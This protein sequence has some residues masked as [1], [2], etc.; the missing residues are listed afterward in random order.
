MHQNMI[1][2]SQ[3]KFDKVFLEKLLNKLT[4]GNKRSLHLNAIPGR[5]KTKLDLMDISISV[6]QEG[7][8]KKIVENNRAHMFL[9]SLF[10]KERFSFPIY[11][12]NMNQSDM[13]E[14]VKE[15]L[16][17][18]SKKLDAIIMD[19]DEHYLETGSKNFGLGYPLLVKSDKKEPKNIIIA[20]IFIWSLD[21]VKSKRR[22]E[23]IISRDED[24]P[25]K[26]NELLISHIKKD[27]G[28]VLPTLD[29][30]EDNILSEREVID[31]I[32]KLLNSFNVSQRF[33][34]TFL[35][36]CLK[37]KEIESITNGSTWIQ[38]SGIF[39]LYNSPKQSIIEAT[40]ELI[41]N[42]DEFKS[43]TL[44][45]QP[46]QNVIS[47][48]F[49]VDPSQSKI[50]D[51]IDKNEFKVIQGPPGTGKSQA[52]SA[53]IS[54][55]LANGAKI[56]VVCEKKTALDV[57]EEN[58]KKK[59]L[60]TF[61]IVID[62][63]VK[64][65]SHVVKKARFLQ[66]TPLSIEKFDEGEFRTIHNRYLGLRNKINDLYQVSSKR[67]FKNCNL[68]DIIGNFL[69]YSK[70]EYF[71]E[72]KDKLSHIDF[73]FTPEELE[74]YI[75]SIANAILLCEKIQDIDE[76]TFSLIDLSQF[77]ERILL[78]DIEDIKQK[79][80]N[81]QEII[82]RT[83]SFLELSSF[84]VNG[85]SIGTDDSIL[86][87]EVEKAKSCLYLYKSIQEIYRDPFSPQMISDI[88]TQFMAWNKIAE[89]LPK[90][91]DVIYFDMELPSKIEF[92]D[93][94]INDFETISSLY[95]EGC[96][97]QGSRFDNKKI[98]PL[99][100]FFSKSAFEAYRCTQDLQVLFNKIK[101]CC[102]LL[103]ER[104]KVNVILKHWSQYPSISDILEASKVVVT[105]V[106]KK[107]EELHEQ[108]IL[109]Y[110]SIKHLV[111]KVEI[112]R[113][114]CVEIIECKK[115]IKQSA[116]E[117][118]RL[119][120]LINNI[121]DKYRSVE[122][123]M[124]TLQNITDSLQLLHSNLGYL[125]EYN[126]WIQFYNKHQG[127][128]K[129]F[130]KIPNEK[131]RESFLGVYYYYYI[132]N[133]DKN[134]G[135]NSGRD[136]TDLDRLR[137]TYSILQ[138]QNNYKIYN[139]WGTKRRKTIDRLELAVGFKTLFALKGTKRAGRKKSLRQ[140]IEWDFDAFTS[141][142]PVVMVNPVVANAL[143]PLKQGLFDLV[144]FDEASQ[145][146][147]ED[148]YTSMIRGKYKVVV[149]DKH[150]MPPSNYFSSNVES[151]DF[152]N[153]DILEGERMRMEEQLEAESLLTF[154]E[155]IPSKNSSN[156]DFHYR[157][158][159]PALIEFSNSAFYGGNLCPLPAKSDYCP[160]VLREVGGIYKS[161]SLEGNINSD[162][163]E[164]VLSILR[165]IEAN[166][167]GTM[168][169][170][171]VVTFNIHQRN[172]I[173]SLLDS[174]AT[175]DEQ[176]Q[177]K[178]IE[179][180]KSGLFVRNLENVQGD[181]RDVIILSTTFGNDEE[182]V[183]YERFG[184]INNQKGYRLINV[185]ITRAKKQIFLVTS[186]PQ[187]KYIKYKE[188]IEVS[189]ENNKKAIFYAYLAYAKAVSDGQLDIAEDI[190]VELRRFSYDRPK[191]EQSD[192]HHDTIGFTESPFEEEVYDEIIKIVGAEAVKIQ[193]K[194]GGY[195]LDFLVEFKGRKIA[196]ECDGKT[197]H[198]TEQAYIEDMH[199]Q[200]TL[201]ALGYIFYRVWSIN[202]FED[203]DKEISKFSRW[204]DTL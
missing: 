145:L 116:S 69:K 13:S 21:I 45:I 49:D 38:W 156:L 159:H 115:I 114:S 128:F 109:S 170:V 101:S 88:N 164:E 188:L 122:E 178:Y 193:Y 42:I 19:N 52:I 113:K 94:I 148:V 138:S 90:V 37:K 97:L 177:K 190:L 173:K 110:S 29:D 24:S 91:I 201:E 149:G 139:Y 17:K 121:S 119:F 152:E 117:L 58:L 61:C 120:P 105:L 176:F 48:S 75:A 130:I 136:S 167:D 118:L 104:Y 5:A 7:T 18:V 15:E 140:I 161:K 16:T 63:V 166:E 3:I 55:A 95:A 144:V 174:V 35:E 80:K 184:S 22:N 44:K 141:L 182:G 46:F 165:D 108:F 9:D 131:W 93:T 57:L 112:Y 60:D 64:D 123:Y 191:D 66:E 12:D 82:S 54:N 8:E 86:N 67:H 102:K 106:H 197:Y 32:N 87:K 127:F 81:S 41:D 26:V 168:P 83:I 39:G 28:I 153:E 84:T 99:L 72:L 126:N 202:W 30:L 74:S 71:S 89:S 185:L 199:R 133:Y 158:E 68:K 47:T 23:W 150:Q 157:S 43:E 100:K 134:Y 171:G 2:N 160:I 40:R 98:N 62:D 1:E 78:Q 34:K 147:L 194:V 146:K 192:I 6:V 135:V 111:E 180:Q 137:E 151:D 155:S 96:S 70:S 50:I 107:K 187:S 20:P 195:R 33:E 79:I 204:L 129:H 132:L 124:L 31:Y 85:F 154:V 142:F 92:L 65:R 53:I 56:L 25:I 10:T 175:D 163:A 51:T 125:H 169:S 198:S 4:V 183:F 181:E 186:I 73:Q 196:L 77:N 203:K 179:L 59:N 36:K 27:E 172:Y 103:R 189:R 14:E 162:E 76:K 143:F 11:W 200:K